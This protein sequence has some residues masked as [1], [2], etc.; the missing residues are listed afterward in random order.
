MK[1]IT[2][3]TLSTLCLLSTTALGASPEKASLKAFKSYVKQSN[4]HDVASFESFA[5]GAVFTRSDDGGPVRELPYEAIKDAWP[6]IMT[7]SK[8]RGEKETYSNL[9]AVVTKDGVRITGTRYAAVKCATDNDFFVDMAEREGEWKITKV[10]STGS[11]LSDCPATESAQRYVSSTLAQL[12]GKLPYPIDEDTNLLGLELRQN[13]VIQV[14]QLHTVSNQETEL[15][16][17]LFPALRDSLQNYYCST[18]MLKEMLDGNT[19]VF[20]P[21]LGKEKT[22]LFTVTIQTCP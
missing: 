15:I 1:R 2:F 5:D 13:N 20:H 4:N 17:K 21:Y 16:E 14:S 6:Q 19:F 8:T 10:H 11:A 3:L 12:S 7:M 9:K 22:T 18:P